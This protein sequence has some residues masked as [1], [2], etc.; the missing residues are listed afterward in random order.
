MFILPSLL[1]RPIPLNS[2]PC[3]SLPCLRLQQPG[4]SPPLCPL[5]ALYSSWAARKKKQSTPKHH[6]PKGNIKK[7]KRKA[8][9]CLP[10]S[11]HRALPAM[12]LIRLCGGRETV[13][14]VP[15][16]IPRRIGACPVSLA[17]LPYQCGRKGRL[18]GQN[19]G[20]YHPK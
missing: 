13:G 17:S 9:R 19:A 2:F 16:A 12:T 11:S 8:G 20:R 5:S 4:S 10:Q 14:T 1:I 6:T 7:P 18:D 15:R 3:L